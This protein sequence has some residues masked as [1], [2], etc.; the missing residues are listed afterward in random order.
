MESALAEIEF[1]ARSPNRVAVLRRLAEGRHTRTD[2]VVATGLHIGGIMSSPAV[3][4]AVRSL[5]TGESV[6]FSLD[7]FRLARF[8]TRSS[9]FPFVRHMAE[10]DITEARIEAHRSPVEG[11]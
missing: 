10:T 9:A 8:D 11:E 4:T 2:L 5:V 3:A 7:P 6:P 1:L